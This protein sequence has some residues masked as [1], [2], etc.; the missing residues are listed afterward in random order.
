MNII[1]AL[2]LY[3]AGR[4]VAKY[5][6]D[7]WLALIIQLMPFGNIYALNAFGRLTPES[8]MIVPILLMIVFLINRLDFFNAN[9]FYNLT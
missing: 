9:R 7:I 3:F 2:V 8:L 1:I 5:S 4:K 6:N